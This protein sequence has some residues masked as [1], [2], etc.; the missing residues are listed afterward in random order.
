MQ[1]TRIAFAIPA[2]RNARWAIADA[3]QILGSVF[4][5]TFGGWSD[6]AECKRAEVREAGLELYVEIEVPLAETMRGLIRIANDDVS[7][8]A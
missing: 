1:T 3:D 5:L 7:L 4:P 8:K 6:T 2:P